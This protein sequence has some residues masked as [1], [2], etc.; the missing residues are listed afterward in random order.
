[1]CLTY[2]NYM[3]I[4]RAHLNRLNWCRCSICLKISLFLFPSFPPSSHTYPVFFKIDK[5]SI[6][7]RA[8]IVF[9]VSI[10][11]LFPFL[12]FFLCFLCFVPVLFF[13]PF[14]GVFSLSRSC[15]ELLS[16]CVRK[17]S[18]KC[19]SVCLCICMCKKNLLGWC[20]YFCRFQIVCEQNLK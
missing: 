15:C 17:I 10:T 5:F 1:M 2:Q 19:M 12:C 11:P 18:G 3:C 20:I 4:T 8:C 6:P 13:S 9:S 14:F 16:A 7:S